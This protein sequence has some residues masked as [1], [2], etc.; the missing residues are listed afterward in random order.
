MDNGLI[1][2]ELGISFL[3]FLDSTDLGLS[4]CI[5]LHVSIHLGPPPGLALPVPLRLSLSLSL[6]CRSRKECTSLTVYEYL[7]EAIHTRR[8]AKKLSAASSEKK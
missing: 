2:S 6:A 1:I 5:Y 7:G 3:V 4:T 8:M